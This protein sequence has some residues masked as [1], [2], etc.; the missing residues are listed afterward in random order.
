[1]AWGVYG[2]YIKMARAQWF[3]VF[4]VGFTVVGNLT[5]VLNDMWLTWWTQDSFELPQAV[6]SLLYV[7]SSMIYASCTFCTAAGLW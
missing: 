6:Y 7:L 2:G 5:Q 1:M 3:F 4:T